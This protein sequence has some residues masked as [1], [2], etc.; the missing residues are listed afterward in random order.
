M[1][2]KRKKPHN[3]VSTYP[4]LRAYKIQH[5]NQAKYAPSFV[6]HSKSFS[7]WSPII[8]L[9]LRKILEFSVKYLYFYS[10]L[11]FQPA[12]PAFASIAPSSQLSQLLGPK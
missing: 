1:I 12:F 3:T 2:V 10:V 6:F 11:F 8:T 4:G 9:F 7:D 5:Q